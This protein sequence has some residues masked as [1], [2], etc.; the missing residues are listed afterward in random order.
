VLGG[1]RRRIAWGFLVGWIGD[2]SGRGTYG[3]SG[4]VREFAVGCSGGCEGE[5]VGLCEL[6]SCFPGARLY[7]SGEMP[8]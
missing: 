4:H 8:G 3:A 7:C 6:H 5:Q 2:A 1:W